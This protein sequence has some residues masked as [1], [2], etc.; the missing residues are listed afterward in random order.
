MKYLPTMSKACELQ[1][2]D[3][4]PRLSKGICNAEFLLTFSETII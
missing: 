1:T 4:T 2:I 3:Y